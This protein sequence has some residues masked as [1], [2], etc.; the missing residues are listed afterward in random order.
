MSLDDIK[1]TLL[2]I[3]PAET[4]VKHREEGDVTVTEIADK[5]LSYLDSPEGGQY[6]EEGPAMTS[7]RAKELRKA[8]L[9][10]RN[11]L[12]VTLRLAVGHNPFQVSKETFSIFEMVSSYVVIYYGILCTT[13]IL[14]KHL[15]LI[16]A[17]KTCPF[18]KYGKNAVWRRRSGEATA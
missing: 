15:F 5:F 16:S 18:A 4:T 2:A 10:K 9:K 17:G 1:M 11:H 12:F 7:K 14:I 13:F 3:M 6:I 8:L